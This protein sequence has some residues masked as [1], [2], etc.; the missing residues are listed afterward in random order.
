MK[1]MLFSV[2]VIVSWSLVLTLQAIHVEDPEEDNHNNDNN[3]ND[4]QQRVPEQPKHVM[5][6][7]TTFFLSVIP[8][9]EPIRDDTPS[10]TITTPT[11]SESQWGDKSQQAEPTTSGIAT[12]PA[13]IYE[14]EGRKA[15]D[16]FRYAISTYNIDLSSR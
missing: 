9:Q 12:P 1:W 14:D 15:H 8:V 16:H 10:P 7:N 5:P 4:D 3:N 6:S 11:S 2:L 13:N